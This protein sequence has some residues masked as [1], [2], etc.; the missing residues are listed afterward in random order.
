MDYLEGIT[1]EKFEELT[2]RQAYRT[3]LIK[4]EKQLPKEKSKAEKWSEKCRDLPPKTGLRGGRN[5]SIQAKTQIAWE[6]VRRIEF[7]MRILKRLLGK[8]V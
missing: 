2:K 3:L 7:Q 6:E 4:L 8:E 1:E 5:S